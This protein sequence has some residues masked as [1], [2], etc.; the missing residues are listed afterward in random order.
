VN[1][2]EQIPRKTVAL[3]ATATTTSKPKGRPGRDALG[4]KSIH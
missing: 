2:R 3:A 4:D 1:P